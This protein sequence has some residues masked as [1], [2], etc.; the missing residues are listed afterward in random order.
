MGGRGLVSAKRFFLLGI[1]ALFLIATFVFS[2]PELGNSLTGLFAFDTTET[3][4]DVSGNAGNLTVLT[5]NG[6]EYRELDEE[7][8]YPGSGSFSAEA[9]IR[10]AD[11]S[12]AIIVSTGECCGI[13]SYWAFGKSW[14]V[15]RAFFFVKL[16][17]GTGEISGTGTRNIAD[18][19]WHQLVFVRDREN[20]EVR[21]YVD[22]I[23]DIEFEDTTE[24]IL[25]ISSKLLAG[26]GNIYQEEWFEGEIASLN[27]YAHALTEDE[28]K[29]LYEKGLGKFSGGG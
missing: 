17:D 10:T 2:P 20:K 24:E 13:E 7:N 14:S 27:T 28:I 29:G 8:I 26:I 5:L 4:P 19:G 15:D 3:A 23:Q 22:G 11:I 18:G 6:S 12:D 1:I 9:W 16:N 21:G 25:D